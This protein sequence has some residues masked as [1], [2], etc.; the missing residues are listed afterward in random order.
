MAQSPATRMNKVGIASSPAEVLLHYHA[1]EPIPGANQAILTG[2]TVH[3]HYVLQV[4]SAGRHSVFHSPLH[5]RYR[6]ASPIPERVTQKDGSH[7]QK[8]RDTPS[9]VVMAQHVTCPP[10]ELY[11][12][13]S[14]HR[15][16]TRENLRKCSGRVAG[17]LTTFPPRNNGSPRSALFDIEPSSVKP[18]RCRNQA[19]VQVNAASAAQNK[20]IQHSRPTDYFSPCVTPRNSAQLP[21][22][23]PASNPRNHP[24]P[25]LPNQ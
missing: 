10:H 12:G 24:A 11:E 21:T 19:T 17:L 7:A 4:H 22:P 13:R 18:P 9:R 3:C 5:Y 23:L 14:S 2:K 16:Q 25:H 20:P 15:Q 8:S 1:D 6:I